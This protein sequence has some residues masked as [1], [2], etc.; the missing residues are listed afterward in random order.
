MW[1]SDNDDDGN[2]GTRI[3]FVMEFGNYGYKDEFTGAAWKT[4]RTGMEAEIPLQHW[5]LNDPGVMP[6]LLQTGAGSPTGILIYEGKLLPKNFQNQLV[7]CDA[8]PNVVRAYPVKNSGAGYSAES[9][10]VLYGV[11]DTWFRPSDVCVAPDGSLI[12]ADWYDPAV[13]G[14]RMQDVE[15][16]RLFRVAPPGSKYSV[17]KVDVST[18]EGAI[19]ALDSP[20]LAVRQ[21]AWF[22]LHNG[23]EP[24]ESALRKLFAESDDQRLRARALWLLGKIESRGSQYVAEAIKDAN[25]DIRITGLRIARQLKLDIIPL[26]KTLA[27]DS[28]AQV[29]REVAVAIRHN[30]SSEVA[31]IWADLALQHD[32]KDRW[33]LEAL[34][35]SAD[36]QWDAFLAAWLD[37]VGDKVNSDAARDILWRSRGTDSP[38]HL[39]AVIQSLAKE[40]QEVSPRYLRAFDF[41]KSPGTQ[42]ALVQLAFMGLPTKYDFVATEAINRIQGFD[43]NKNAAAKAALGRV[44]ATSRGTSQFVKLVEKFELSDHY[45]ELLNLAVAH[46]T[47]QLGADA[48]TALLVKQQSEL[49]KRGLNAEKP[50][51]GVAVAEALAT[52]GDGRAPE[53]TL[54]IITNKDSPL[55]LRRACVRA[56]ASSKNGALQ[57]LAMAK[58][59]DLDAGLVPAVASKLHASP[60]PAVRAEAVKMFPLPPSINANPLPPISDL[61]QRKGDA[62]RGLVIYQKTGTCANCHLVNK[63]GKDVGPDLSEIGSKLSRVAFFESIL[64]PSAGVSHNYETYSII[65]NDG[66][67]VN[68]ILASQ[69]DAAVTIKTDKAIVREIKRSDIDEIVKQP[70][71]MMPA[72]IQKLMTEQELVDVVE[73]LTTLKKKSVASASIERQGNAVKQR[74]NTKIEVNF[75]R[76]PLQEAIA[77]VSIGCKV[78]VSIDAD[79][80]KFGSSRNRVRG[81]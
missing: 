30:R 81:W 20:N 2:R 9:V 12:I 53:L 66:N 13:G 45:A 17:P 14:H 27:S 15:R 51:N 79:A 11:R 46:P 22:V 10:N 63:E 57:I 4:P 44:L 23:R 76:T 31:R 38:R 39:A 3:N 62:A 61:A 48:I 35:S 60:D 24:A 25:P 36:G 73:Y 40:D 37:K 59:G 78:S 7:H 56:C 69:T 71:S 77:S 58:K 29:R 47:E 1:Q 19:A 42:D 72:D 52:A 33:Y 28:S 65:L 68:G 41:Q 49:I 80:L 74:L 75:R 67:T 21:M 32:G 34:G 55:E 50:E 18:I 26:A 6:N 43:I 8:G 16:G 54:P 70:T 64:F 5:H